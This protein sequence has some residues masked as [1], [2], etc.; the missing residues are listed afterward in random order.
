MIIRDFRADADLVGRRIVVSWVVD[1]EGS[2][3]IA[4][5]PPVVLR[6]KTRDFSFPPPASP[7][8]FL[9][10]DSALGSPAGT[11]TTD[12]TPWESV[13][14]DLRTITAVQ[15]ASRM[16]AGRPV[17]VFRRTGATVLDPLGRVRTRRI[18]ILDLGDSIGGLQP[19]TVYYYRLEIAWPGGTT[20]LTACAAAGEGFGLSRTMFESLPAV[21]K[22]HDVVTRKSTPE[23]EGIPEAVARS[24]QLRRFVDL[25]GTA[26]DSM[27]SGAEGLRGL[28]AIDSVD[29]R[30]LPFLARTIGWSIPAEQQIAIQRNE[31]QQAPA[32]YKLIGTIPG[33]RL[34]AERL[35]GYRCEVKE[36]IHNVLRTNAPEYIDTWEICGRV[37]SGG[38]WSDPEKLTTTEGFDGRPAIAFDSG[39]TRWL[40]W[41]ADRT[42]RQSIWLSR[43]GVDPVPVRAADGAP[44]DDT[45]YGE[46]NPALVRNGTDMLLFFDSDREGAGDVYMRTFAGPGT[47]GAAQR[48]T[49]GPFDD[50]RSAACRDAAGRIHLAWRSDRRGNAEIWWRMRTGSAWSD[51][52]RLSDAVKGDDYPAL[53]ADPGGAVRVVW[54]SDR[55]DRTTLLT[56]EFTGGAWGPESSIT[57]ERFRDMAPAIAWYDARMH[58]VWH[59]NREKGWR[60][61]YS[62]LNAGT[63]DPPQPL[64]TW[65]APHKEPGA[66]VDAGG[67][68]RLV[69]R[70]R[71]GGRRFASRTVDTADADMM[72]RL[73]TSH[74][75]AHYLY[76]AGKTDADRYAPDTV[77]I[78]VFAPSGSDPDAVSAAVDKA[79]INMEPFRPLTTRLVWITAVE[80]FEETVEDPE[81]IGEEIL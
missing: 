59:A 24:G 73:Q 3:N 25:F 80:T 35:T 17:E 62:V 5:I 46:S 27:R 44:D 54:C 40:A 9:V 16:I 34:W 75:R 21:I 39:G 28:R 63:W 37:L 49:E 8:P 72:A 30:M 18:E 64:T 66:A 20:L 32:L 43:D 23:T 31:V 76:D 14:D 74:D 12:L 53:A 36:F 65:Y 1:L 60:L 7:D 57:A 22:R 38:V 10:Y 29:Y 55:G 51:P 6:R 68:L 13:T 2:G 71:E 4:G 47:A 19:G 79:R 61:W 33:L 56:R 81:P 70:S 45:T 78:Y 15:S 58:L 41:H 52:V 26:C 69:W 50:R 67:D 42:A 77:G 11:V 48:L